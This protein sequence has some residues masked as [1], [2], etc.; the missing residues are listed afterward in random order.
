MS[1]GWLNEIASDAPGRQCHF[2][3]SIIFSIG[4]VSVM[5]LGPT[6]LAALTTRTF[7]SGCFRAELHDD[8]LALEFALLVLVPGSGDEVDV[9]RRQPSRRHPG[10]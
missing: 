4:T 8:L 5:S 7:M 1:F 3:C 10:S 2:P 9:Y 6:A